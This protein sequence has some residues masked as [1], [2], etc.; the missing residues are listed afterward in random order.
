MYGGWIFQ[1]PV[2]GF[3]IMTSDEF[4]EWLSATGLSG[5]QAAAALGIHH[6]TVGN[7][8][9]GRRGDGTPVEVPRTVALACAALYHRI[10]PWGER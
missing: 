10:K 5:N 7:Y 4:C 9:R 2:L 6:E 1:R 8:R 3:P